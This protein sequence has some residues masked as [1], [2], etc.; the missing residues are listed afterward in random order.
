M[1]VFFRAIYRIIF[2]KVSPKVSGKN[3]SVRLNCFMSK[4]EVVVEGDNNQ[5]IIT[6]GNTIHNSTIHVLGS[7]CKVF[8]DS[9]RDMRNCKIIVKG[10]GS[11]L[12]IGKNY[13]IGSGRIVCKGDVTIGADCMMADGIEIWS[14]DTH[15]IIDINTNSVINQDDAIHIG[16]HVWLGI[17][18]R[19]LK[20][21]VISKDTVVGMGSIVSKGVYPANCILAGVPAKKIR[22]DISWRI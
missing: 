16:D 19:V 2:C 21:S 20:G 13:S 18:V 6:D 17:S 4:S 9:P 14:S 11:S 22:D 12:T 1:Y 10:D 8:I 15:E 3:N 7:N 5:I